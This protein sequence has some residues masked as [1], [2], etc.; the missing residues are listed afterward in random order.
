MDNDIISVQ[1]DNKEEKTLRRKAKRRVNM[2]I[3]FMIFFLVCLILWLF[4]YFLFK[5]SDLGSGMFRFCLGLTLIWAVIVYAHYLIIFKW[6]NRSV[7]K[8]IKKLRKQEEKESE[9]DYPSNDIINS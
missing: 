2:R 8:E 5:N 4:Y 3:H 7:D 1:Q 6:G 9:K